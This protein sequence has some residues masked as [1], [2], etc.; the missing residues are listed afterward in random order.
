MS[1]SGFGQLYRRLSSKLL[2]LVV[3]PH[4][5]GEV[6]GKSPAEEQE[7]AEVNKKITCYVLQ[8]YSRSNA[9]IVDAETR[10][11]QLAP[12]LDPLVIAEHKE[13][14]S[15]LFLQHH[16]EKNLLNPPAHNFPPRLL[17]LIELLDQY[18]QYDI[19]LVPV[20]VLWGR[21]PDKEDSWFKL[22][23]TDTWATPG[24]VKQLVN[25]GLHGRETYLEF[26]EGQSLRTLVEYA[27][28]N[29]PNL[30]AATYIISTL[31]DYLDC[32]REVVLGPDL[33]DRRNV[34]QSLIK[35]RDVQEAIRRES[36]RGK[37][38]MLEAERRAIGYLNEIVSDYSA[39]A[40]RFADMAL[41]RLWTQLYDGVEVHNFNTVRELAKDYE[42]IYTPCH[43]SHIDYLLLSY[44]IYKRGL[45]VPYI[46][47]GDNL[48]MPFVG[49]LLR[50]GGAFFIRRSFRGNAL[51]TSVFKE[52]LY[53]IL[54]RNTPLE[55]FI[56]GGRSR[57]GRLLPP[58][59]GMLAMTVHSHLRGRAKPIAFV[60]TYIG[61]ERLMEG[62][63]YVG[64]M[65]GKPKEAESI[66][67]ILQTLRKIERIFGKVHVNFGE[68]VFLDDLL[69]QH[70]AE[71]IVIE[72][73]D[74]P[75]PAAVSEAINSSAVAILENINRAVVI[76]P[77]S[78]LSLILL[79]TP[80]HTLDEEVCIKQLDAYRR[81]ASALPYDER[82]QV[83]PLSGKEIIA[84]GLKLKLIKRV[85]HVLG[86]II[87]I[88]DNQAVLLTY[89][90]NNILHSFVLPSLVA[91]LVE[92][93]GK[94]SRGDLISVIRTLYPFLK[95]ELFLKWN[96]DEL[97]EQICQNADALIQGGLMSQDEEGNLI[98]SAPNT[99]EHNQLVV[100]AAPV[101]QSLERYY[102]TL[103]LI[104]QRGSGTISAKQVEDLSHLLGQRLSVL[105][106]FNSPEFFDKALFQ[107]F[108]KVL[109]QQE[110]IRTNENGLIEFDAGFSN[111]AE[112]AKLV[113]DEVTLQMLHH[114]T[115]FSD[116]ELQ[117]AL[118]AVAAQ[119]AKRRL[120][121]KRK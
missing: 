90:R 68:P 41:T 5:I 18:P 55:Y 22:L 63:T 102:M 113:L 81:L 20:T 32:Q 73:N 26:H 80:K 121:R 9:L 11:L 118:N 27:K 30:S 49:Q 44:V 100:L 77:V 115:D 15:V 103:A 78:L 88:E 71:N 45:M 104:T 23:F 99:E 31:N 54:S 7:L 56:E 50:G 8:N 59:T 92:H 120:M 106:E 6:P 35:S 25:I 87:A 21:S 2:D 86:D 69:K 3:T 14:A 10:R 19:E 1:K 42:I 82:T 98:S 43:R 67:G 112:G 72:K 79:A 17:R 60:P 39:S 46:A 89:F 111:M 28:E 4:V 29:Y 38:S 62:A 114:I 40:V 16:D 36:I 110:Y 119:Q 108:I 37:I 64:E 76:N 47:A 85:Q 83:T 61:Y 95:A 66:F 117:E 94:I 53:S 12:A 24:K 101:K 70:G 51:Y 109:T 96:T 13:K 116:E 48:N 74:D 33:S 65:Q 93:N 58:K 97:K 57:T 75:V 34:M 84:Y 91:S 105:Y 52:Y 107:S